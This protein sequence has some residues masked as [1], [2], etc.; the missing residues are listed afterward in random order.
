MSN[1]LSIRPEKIYEIFGNLKG[2]VEK[3]KDV[4]KCKNDLTVMKISKVYDYYF[5]L[6][7]KYAEKD[8]E[9]KVKTMKDGDKNLTKNGCD[10]DGEIVKKTDDLFS[11][12][13]F[14]ITKDALKKATRLFITIIFYREKDKEIKIK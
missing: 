6:I 2:I 4:F 8:L 14:N 11:K 10:L 13:D 1:I 7:F 12:K 9:K 3:F 5:K